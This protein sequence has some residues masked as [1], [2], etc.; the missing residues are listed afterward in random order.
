MD[1]NIPVQKKWYDFEAN[2]SGFFFNEMLHVFACHP[3]TKAMLLFS[4][5]FQF[6]IMYCQGSTKY[7]F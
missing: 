3:C 2:K 1:R 5:S 6:D 4:I 7:G